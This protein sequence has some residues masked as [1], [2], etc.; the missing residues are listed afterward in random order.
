MRLSRLSPLLATALLAVSATLGAADNKN[1]LPLKLDKET[2]AFK[3]GESL[4]YT[5]HYKW[6]LVNADV[7]QATLKMDSTVL[8]GRPCYHGSLRGK[9]QKLY[10]TVFK[11]KE[12]FD[13]WFTAD[14][15]TPMRFTRDCRE[16]GYWCTNLYTYHSDHIDAQINNSRKGE[17]TVE[18]PRDNCTYDV[19]SLFF[20]IRNMDISKL[21]AGGRY[22][23]SYACD[24]KVRS[25]Y[26]KYYGVEN[27][28][29]PG[30]GLVR[31][32]K[33]GFEVPKGEAFEG[34]ESLFAWFSDDGNRVPVSFIAPLK[35]GQVRGRLNSSTGLRHPFTSVVE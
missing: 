30:K 15:F 23:M 21:K 32:H 19:A 11:L 28:K 7:A 34:D 27:Q 9:I 35:I 3:G 18:L 2:L 6:G 8:N 10:E 4:V 16:G 1:C 17:F 33:F 25:I 13:C 12:D 31:C 22:P 26:F 24:H 14:T 29:V 5:I 20:L